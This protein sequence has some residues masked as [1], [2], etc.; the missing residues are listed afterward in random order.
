MIFEV[1][2]FDT[3]SNFCCWPLPVVSVLRCHPTVVLV[4]CVLDLGPVSSSCVLLNL[5]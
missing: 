5:D 2:N 3:N 1:H 4:L